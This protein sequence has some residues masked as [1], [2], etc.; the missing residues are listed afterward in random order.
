MVIVVADEGKGIA[1]EHLPNIFR[2]FF[3]TKGHGTGLG[4]SLARRTVEAHG[5][6][7]DVAAA[8]SAR[9]RSSPC[10]LPILESN[11]H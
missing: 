1:P 8:K 5:G 10:G 11:S 9:A 4:L 6:R 3:T 2:P 7:I